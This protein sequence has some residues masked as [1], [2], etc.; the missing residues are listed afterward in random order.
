MGTAGRFTREQGFR[1]QRT[2]RS[3]CLWSTLV[4]WSG[5]R[6]SSVRWDFEDSG[7]A[8]A[9][10]ASVAVMPDSAPGGHDAGLSTTVDAAGA[11]A[12]AP[13]SGV[14]HDGGVPDGGVVD[15]GGTQDGG[16]SIPEGAVVSIVEPWPFSLH[17]VGD[18]VG[19]RA[20]CTPVSGGEVANVRW[21]VRGQPAA[22]GVSAQ[23]VVA[24]EVGEVNIDVECE[25]T[26]GVR[27]QKS[28]PVTFLETPRFI[29]H[30]D[31]LTPGGAQLYLGDVRQP[32]TL[33]QLDQSK[34]PA[35]GQTLP[36]L[37][38][39]DTQAPLVS[40]SGSAVTAWPSGGLGSPYV[41]EG[42]TNPN[43]TL[44]SPDQ[45]LFAR[46]DNSTL[47]LFLLGDSGAELLLEQPID[48]MP[49]R[50]TPD[51]RSILWANP[52][53]AGNTWYASADEGWIPHL[54]ALPGSGG[55]STSIFTVESGHVALVGT[56]LDP[57]PTSVVSIAEQSDLE[58]WSVVPLPGGA[59]FVGGARLIEA[60]TR[61]TSGDEFETM[62]T[63]ARWWLSPQTGT[64]HALGTGKALA[65]CA[66]NVLTHEGDALWVTPTSGAPWKLCD[67]QS[68]AFAVSRDCQSVAAR[69]SDD[70]IV[71][72]SFTD[73][74]ADLSVST[75]M[76]ED[77]EAQ[78]WAAS[79]DGSTVAVRRADGRLQL[80]QSDGAGGI[81]LAWEAP[82]P[83]AYELLGF[84]GSDESLLYVN[85]G[86][87]FHDEV[88]S[89]YEFQSLRRMRIGA[90][91][92]VEELLFE[93]GVESVLLAHDLNS[94]LLYYRPAIDDAEG[95]YLQVDLDGETP[96]P[97]VAEPVRTRMV[98]SFVYVQSEARLLYAEEQTAPLT[99]LYSVDL[100]RGAERT[101]LASTMPHRWR[102]SQAAEQT[103]SGGPILL[104]GRTGTGR[105]SLRLV[106]S[107]PANAG[108]S[109]P[110]LW[111]GQGVAGVWCGRTLGITRPGSDVGALRW[112]PAGSIV[113]LAPNPLFNDATSNGELGFWL[114]N[115]EVGVVASSC[116]LQDPTIAL[117]GAVTAWGKWAAVSTYDAAAGQSEFTLLVPGKGV[118]APKLEDGSRLSDSQGEFDVSA[119][120]ESFVLTMGD[121]PDYSHYVVRRR[122]PEAAHLVGAVASEGKLW[123]VSDTGDVLLFG[124]YGPLY[125]FDWVRGRTAEHE[126][127]QGESVLA[128]APDGSSMVVGVGYGEEGPQRVVW[129]FDEGRDAVVVEGHNF[130]Y[131]RGGR[132][133]AA[134][135]QGG[136]WVMDLSRASSPV[137]LLPVEYLLGAQVIWLP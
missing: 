68:V 103:P 26:T 126:L 116:E 89:G 67:A 63:I 119:R 17:Y 113:T 3:A 11:D 18:R 59:N 106:A 118:V 7:R 73:G 25:L 52:T 46:H 71:L 101:T 93:G 42:A 117:P 39:A 135:Y 88:H 78:T 40:V 69:N 94:F 30:A 60:E 81:D 98:N 134:E 61:V 112:E 96:T 124:G 36:G 47:R 49:P 131:D 16:A 29:L 83:P 5:C 121:Y 120:Y 136:A 70:H 15:V 57:S 20:E 54:L 85:Q 55:V 79:S 33:Q 90:Q 51:S 13:D 65:D 87:L 128:L 64:W 97:I 92:F 80:W 84:A 37:R 10:D 132:Y 31:Q 104:D 44:V 19:V 77:V 8:V 111:E 76:V 91:P 2:V 45:R 9:G 137:Q 102:L 105:E 53:P 35:T 122:T 28:V 14:E 62:S 12:G 100:A 130:S 21:S 123:G 4:V 34:A 82:G 133:L 127:Q 129:P 75:D 48:N 74:G 24:N 108:K 109:P 1:S 32:A 56:A 86:R 22:V 66:G 115:T 50:F 99:A 58:A 125:V 110:V 27:V 6:E 72:A 107:V 38:Y 95:R 114:L 41:A 43:L 23:L